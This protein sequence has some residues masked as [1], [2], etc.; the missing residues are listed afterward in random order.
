[1]AANLSGGEVC[2]TIDDAG[3]A[4]WL[5]WRCSSISWKMV[6]DGVHQRDEVNEGRVVVEGWGDFF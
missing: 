4:E 3:I 2:N 6:I 5:P 1:M